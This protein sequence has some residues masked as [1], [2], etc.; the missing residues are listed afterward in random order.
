ML[1][2]KYLSSLLIKKETDTY[3]KL[4]YSSPIFNDSSN[5]KSSFSSK[6]KDIKINIKM[7]EIEVKKEY[8]KSQLNRF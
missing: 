6:S 5:T 7:L 4:N 8:M 2:G 3:L 1:S